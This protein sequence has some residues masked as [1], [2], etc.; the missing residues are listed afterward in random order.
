MLKRL[1]SGKFMYE[2]E[3]LLNFSPLPYET[4]KQKPIIVVEVVKNDGACPFHI[5]SPSLGEIVHSI[6]SPFRN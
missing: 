6:L 1:K 5:D 4:R 3:S 2:F